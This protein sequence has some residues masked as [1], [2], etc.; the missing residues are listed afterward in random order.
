MATAKDP[1]LG[2]GGQAEVGIMHTNMYLHTHDTV[3]L[4]S[5]SREFQEAGAGHSF[6][7]LN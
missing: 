5:P 3:V 1:T 6:L 2:A 7:L 4:K